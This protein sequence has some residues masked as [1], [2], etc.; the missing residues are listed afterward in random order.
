M[1]RLADKKLEEIADEYSVL[2]QVGQSDETNDRTQE[3]E[4]IVL[5]RAAE[6]VRKARG[7]H[8]LTKIGIA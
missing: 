2:K 8:A 3:L 5:R 1:K 4:L 6:V 7:Q